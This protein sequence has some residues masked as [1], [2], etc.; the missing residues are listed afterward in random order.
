VAG[1]G[2]YGL[3]G[4]RGPATSASFSDV[5]GVAVDASGNLNIADTGNYR[6]RKVSADTGMI[7]TVA[8]NGSF[9]VSGD[10]GPA[11]SASFSAVNGLAV[12]GSG[13]LYIADSGICSPRGGCPGPNGIRKVSA[14]TGLITTVAGDGTYGLSGDGGP[15]TSAGLNYPSGVAADSLGNLYIADTGNNRI[16]KVS[17]E[18]GVITTVAGNGTNGSS[19]DNGSATNAS[20]ASPNSLAVD[21]SGNLYIVDTDNN[22][23]RKVSADTGVITTVA[24]NGTYGFSGDNGPATNASLAFPNSLAVDG[25]GNFYLVDRGNRR[26][27]EVDHRIWTTTLLTSNASPSGTQNLVLTAAI[28]SGEAT[29]SVQFYDDFTVL[30]NVALSAGTATLSDL[31]LTVE[32]TPSPPST[33]AT[34]F[35]A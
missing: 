29:G 3:S 28:S 8:G 6:V 21:C 30:G 32:P 16:R 22:R 24:G 14:D 5:N 18:S 34:R 7:I 19:G 17:A 10:G 9:G 2:R 23:I 20:L 12:D 26:V 33:A 11:T 25:S 1:N 13:N 27:R 31:S 35:M 15:A 4:D